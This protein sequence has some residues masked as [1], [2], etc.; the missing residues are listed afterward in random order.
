MNWTLIGILLIVGA[1]ILWIINQITYPLSMFSPWS[2]WIKNN[3]SVANCGTT[4]GFNIQPVTCLPETQ[5][6]YYMFGNRLFYNMATLFSQ[7]KDILE[8]FQIDFIILMMRSFAKDIVP[9]GMLTPK[10]LCCNIVPYPIYGSKFNNCSIVAPPSVKP[11]DSKAKPTNIGST[12]QGAK[13]PDD[14]SLIDLVINTSFKNGNEIPA[15]YPGDQAVADTFSSSQ[16][17]WVTFM[18]AVWGI[19]PVCDPNDKTR[20]IS[21]CAQFDCPNV[22]GKKTCYGG[23]TAPS[24]FLWHNY[25]IGPTSPLVVSFCLNDWNDT[26]GIKLNSLALAHLL[27]CKDHT[28]R[29]GWI[30]L[31]RAFSGGTYGTDDIITYVWSTYVQPQSLV[32]AQKTGAKKSCNASSAAMSG[33]SGALGAGGLF[34]MLGVFTG[35]I[36]WAAAAVATAAIGAGQGLLSA[37]S[38][39][40][41]DKNDNFTL[42]DE[43]DEDDKDKCS[44][45]SAFPSYC[46]PTQKKNDPGTGKDCSTTCKT[47]QTNLLGVF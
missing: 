44:T 3:P 39:G 15:R 33:I 26:S 41:F 17:N 19:R 46:C 29:G 9:G 11:A 28:T 43:T 37:N 16:A 36:G 22:D 2:D 34:A 25:G 40:C 18:V 5:L 14:S 45:N 31:A 8:E 13:L 32:D 20:A 24:N 27:G 7:E 38:S 10:D 6:A 47:S 23:W 35:P 42:Q 30:G 21:V 12:W 4:G 1:I